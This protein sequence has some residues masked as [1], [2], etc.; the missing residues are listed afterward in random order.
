[1]PYNPN[2]KKAIYKWR[3]SNIESYNEYM[4][5]VQVAYRASNKEK[6]NAARMKCYYDDKDPYLKMCKIFR[7]IQI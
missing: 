4:R 5:E 7:K 3:E 2:T 6:A 1:M